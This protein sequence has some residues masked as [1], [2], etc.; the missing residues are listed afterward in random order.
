MSKYELFKKEDIAMIEHELLA[1]TN[2]LEA[3]GST[4]LLWYIQGVIDMAN[5]IIAVIEKGE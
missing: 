3:E 2:V 4:G 5:K 1:S